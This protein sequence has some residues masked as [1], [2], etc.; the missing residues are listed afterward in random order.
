MQEGE[1]NKKKKKKNIQ[2]PCISDGDMKAIQI[3][4]SLIGEP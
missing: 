1:M 4:R 3:C 2:Q